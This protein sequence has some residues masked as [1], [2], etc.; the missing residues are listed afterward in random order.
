MHIGCTLALATTPRHKGLHVFLVAKSFIWET[1]LE[2]LRLTL[3]VRFAFLK[4]PEW[5]VATEDRTGG[6]R[7]ASWRAWHTA[8]SCVSEMN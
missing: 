5:V 7:E 8:I 3:Q 4:K 6:G 1:H 2:G